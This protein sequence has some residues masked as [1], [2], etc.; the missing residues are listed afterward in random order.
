[1]ASKKKLRKEIKRLKQELSTSLETQE[2]WKSRFRQ[3]AEPVAFS[4]LENIIMSGKTTELQWVDDTIEAVKGKGTDER[5][6][7]ETCTGYSSSRSI[8][9]PA[10]GD[11]TWWEDGTDE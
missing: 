10:R 11:T 4:G 7:D 8:R 3:I 9:I 6:M 1:M 2:L 5:T